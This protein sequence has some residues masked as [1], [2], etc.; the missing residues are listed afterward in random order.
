MPVDP[1]TVLG[2][3]V[4]DGETEGVLVNVLVGVCVADG[5]IVLLRVGELV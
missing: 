3:P 2:D 1:V 5:L 4:V